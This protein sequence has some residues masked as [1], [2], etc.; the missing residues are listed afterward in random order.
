MLR[1]RPH[2]AIAVN[3]LAQILGKDVLSVNEWFAERIRNAMVPCWPRYDATTRTT[4]TRSF[5][6]PLSMPP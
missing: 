4:T 2:G 1:P 3:P 6:C 5:V